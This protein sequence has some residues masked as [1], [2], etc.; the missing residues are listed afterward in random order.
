MSLSKIIGG[1]G[2][3]LKWVSITLVV[4]IGVLFAINAVDENPSPEVHV[5]L[6]TTQI[7]DNPGNG[8]L[9]L[10][11]SVVAPANEDFIE[12]G[13]Q[14][15]DVYNVASD[16][17]AIAAANARFP[18]QGIKF[19][20][21]ENQLCNP[22]K[23]PCLP[24]AGERA[25]VW[26]KLAAD[27]EILLTRQRRLV[28]FT[29]FETSYFPPHYESPLPTYSANA[30]RQL[31]LDLIA[32]DAAE[33]RIEQALVSLEARIAFDRRALLDSG[34]IL[35]TMVSVSWLRQDYA[36]LAEIVATRSS[37][38]TAQN[39]R[40]LR[41]TE[42]LESE[43]VRGIAGKMLNGEFRYITR[44]IAVAQD[45]PGSLS[46][47]GWAGNM[48]GRPFFK[49]H[50]TQNLEARRHA[51]IL[52]RVREFTPQQADSLMVQLQQD[53]QT[54]NDDLMHNWRVL[55]NPVGK[56]LSGIMEPSY[57]SYVLKLSDLM[58]VTRLAR[59]QVEVVAEGKSD[60]DIPARI[61]VDKALY[62]PYTGRPMRW[63][64]NQRQIYFDALGSVPSG[65]AKHIGAGI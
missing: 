8:F 15:V 34:D 60:A 47:L 50:A 5:L 26:R 1:V 17:T 9:A 39:D 54:A 10:V 20:G 56:M 41:M 4:F 19:A 13:K 22:V 33:G 53:A 49:M 2:K 57:G 36:L 45:T 6:A 28:E 43:Q 61:A 35:M 48:L 21:D 27:N 62:D 55:Y 32:L 64:A 16:R 30:L 18:S 59:L 12:Y 51:V 38:I 46:E 58:G 65:V 23:T 25:V 44:T 3:P 37:V 31:M 14:W 63:D 29:H 11:G 7:K 40:L 24:L 52:A 42:S